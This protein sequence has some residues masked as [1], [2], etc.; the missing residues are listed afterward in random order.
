[1]QLF[2]LDDQLMV[3]AAHR[4]CLGRCSYIV[5]SCIDWIRLHWDQF[6]R[7]TKLV[8]IRDTIEAIVDDKAGAKYDKGGWIS[9]II[10]LWSTISVEDREW[11]RRAVNFK[12]T[13][14][15]TLCEILDTQSTMD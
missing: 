10:D 3:T 7:N 5:S 2:S 8:L 1:M 9:L 11:I 4:Y 13:K 14:A 6:E 15:I 12:G